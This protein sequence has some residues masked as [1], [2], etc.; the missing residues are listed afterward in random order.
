[1]RTITTA[2]LCLALIFQSMLVAQASQMACA[3]GGAVGSHTAQALSAHGGCCVASSTDAVS[4][5]CPSEMA[6]HG[7]AYVLTDTFTVPL[8][9]ADS[10]VQPSMDEGLRSRYMTEIWRPPTF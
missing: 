3:D 9:L 7:V 1:M 4:V 6:C 5:E 8:A 10:S 2:L